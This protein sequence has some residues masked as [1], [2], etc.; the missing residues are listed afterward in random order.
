MHLPFW[1]LYVWAAVAGASVTLSVGLGIVLNRTQGPVV[2]HAAYVFVGNVA[3]G[4]V[5]LGILA[6]RGDQKGLFPWPSRVKKLGVMG[7]MRLLQGGEA[8]ERPKYLWSCCGG[9]VI[10]PAFVT[11]PAAHLLGTQLCL[12]LVLLGM[13][14]TAFGFDWLA[15]RLHPSKYLA[16][17]MLLLLLAVAIQIVASLHMLEGNKWLCA[18]YSAASLAVGVSYGVQAKMNKRLAR[19]LGSALRAAT[20]CNCSAMAWGLPTILCLLLVGIPFDFL[21]KDWWIWCLNGLQSAFYT[22]SLAHL[23]KLLGY[24]V[25]FILITAGKVFTAA[26]ADSLGFFAPPLAVSLWR[27][28]SVAITVLGAVALTVDKTKSQEARAE[29]ESSLSGDEV[30]RSA[31]GILTT[32]A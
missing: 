3:V 27:Y 1:A 28:L 18:I 11:F 21:A 12:T 23:P 6:L 4:A 25:P 2:P 5:F 7:E 26:L 16:V 13:M 17:G 31:S 32:L 20:F 30:A 15:N 8:C 14:S 10:G 9:L 24:S 22:A 19:D 29:L